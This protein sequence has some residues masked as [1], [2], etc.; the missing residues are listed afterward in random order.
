MDEKDIKIKVLSSLLASLP[1]RQ[2][3]FG[4]SP[5]YCYGFGEVVDAIKDKIKQIESE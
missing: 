5:Q 2:V 4:S 3:A 1:N